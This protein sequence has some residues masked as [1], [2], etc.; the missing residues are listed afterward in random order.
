MSEQWP[1]SPLERYEVP[2]AQDSTSKTT[3]IDISRPGYPKVWNASW[4][5][6]LLY[7]AYLTKFHNKLLV[8]RAVSKYG[9]LSEDIKS[10]IFFVTVYSLYCSFTF[11]LRSS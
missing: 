11:T 3:A 5:G 9:D 10:A 1:F 8:L 6:V 4:G 2:K 7:G